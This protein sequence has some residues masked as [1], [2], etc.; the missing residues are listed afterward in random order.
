MFLSFSGEDVRDNFVSFLY[1]NLCKISSD[2]YIDNIL[3]PAEKIETALM[4]A[5]KRSR[6]AVIIFS[7]SYASSTWCLKELEQIIEWNESHGQMVIPVFYNVDSSH[8]HDPTAGIYA[9]AF[10]RHEWN[11]KGNLVQRFRTAI[12]KALRLAFG[13]LW[14]APERHQEDEKEVDRVQKWKNDMIKAA[15]FKGWDSKVIR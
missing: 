6:I 2:V 11:L 4:E 10:A 3:E 5:I 14:R 8:V 12:S 7:K 13:L 15:N 1:K 9:E